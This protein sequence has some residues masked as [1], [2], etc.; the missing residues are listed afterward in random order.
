MHYQRVPAGQV[1][2]RHQALMENGAPEA[3]GK[4]SASKAQYSIEGL[5]VL[6]EVVARAV[7]RGAARGE[8]REVSMISSRNSTIRHGGGL[9]LH[10]GRRDGK[11]ND[12]LHQ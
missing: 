8:V 12:N 11:N 10:H 6:L 5:Q 3:L 9:K 1:G 2:G 7:V 4:H